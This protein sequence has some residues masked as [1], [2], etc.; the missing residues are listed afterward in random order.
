MAFTT[1]LGKA[2]V[3]TSIIFQAFLLYQDKKEG[4]QFN[5]NLT[6]ALSGCDSLKVVKPYLEQYLRLA[7]VGLLATSALM[8]VVRYWYI[9]AFVILGLSALL[10]V[11]HYKVFEK[12]PTVE[13]L[14]NS[15]F[16][17]SLGVI[18]A[19]IY[20]MGAEGVS[21]I[22]S[23]KPAKATKSSSPAEPVSK[24]AGQKRKGA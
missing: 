18:G 9:K 8:L 19:L 4:D 13:L 5:K 24:N 22:K 16:W 7:V 23:A 11:E 1:L 3:I 20:L 2:L 6:S 14:D 10:W 21:Y 12:V 17:H 15:P